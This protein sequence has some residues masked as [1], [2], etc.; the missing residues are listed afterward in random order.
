MCAREYARER[1]GLKKEAKKNPLKKP[2]LRCV[3]IKCVIEC[4]E[5][6]KERVCVLFVCTCV[7]RVRM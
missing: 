2:Q 1:G 6:K 4:K 5:T 3:Y 7:V